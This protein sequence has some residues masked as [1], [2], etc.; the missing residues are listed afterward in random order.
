MDFQKTVI[1]YGAL[2]SLLI[3]IFLLWY[4]GIATTDK[5]TE[6]KANDDLLKEFID[7]HVAISETNSFLEEIIECDISEIE[8]GEEEEEEEK[9]K[10][11]EKEKEESKESKKEEKEYNYNASLPI[12]TSKGERECRR[13]MEK[14]Y[15][16]PFRNMR[17]IW[18]KNPKTNRCLELD[19]YNPEK[20]IAVE[21]NGKQHY[22]WPNFTNCSYEEFKN[23]LYRDKVKKHI[24][25]KHGVHLITVPYTIPIKNIEK[26]I[27]SRLP[28]E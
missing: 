10:E 16:A 18:L 28:K 13:V 8:E 17:P 22:E 21:Y 3:F 25:K 11:K 9:E 27:R 1:K 5:S 14:I 26:F 19:V 7:D 12:F 4:F 6:K 20:K 15:K 2:I 23:Q 24:C